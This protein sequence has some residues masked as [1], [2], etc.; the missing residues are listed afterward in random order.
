MRL[1]RQWLASNLKRPDVVGAV[2]YSLDVNRDK[3][4]I[5][6]YPCGALTDVDDL[7]ARS[8]NDAE[9]FAAALHGPQ[10][11]LFV[12]ID[13]HERTLASMTF[14]IDGG[15]EG[16]A[17]VA[18]EPPNGVG[19][20]SQLMRHLENRERVTNAVITGVVGMQ[21]RTID[22]LSLQNEKLVSEKF[23]TFELIESLMS[24]KHT[25]DMELKRI[26]QQTETRKAVVEKLGPYLSAM[27]NKLNGAPI[28]RQRASEIEMSAQEFIKEV[29]PSQ[30]DKIAASGIFSPGQLVVFAT[31]LEQ[32]AKVMMTEEQRK[33]QEDAVHKA[34]VGESDKG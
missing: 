34:T 2:V 14:S 15:A 30:M 4:E 16:D 28:V 20:Q 5:S 29:T 17:G 13:E 21:A 32:V 22:R 33:E 19:L 1:E 11:F 18:S 24:G 6:R 7:I 23:G 27:L 8:M 9:A 10:T 12:L 25:R 26:E 3:S 31:M